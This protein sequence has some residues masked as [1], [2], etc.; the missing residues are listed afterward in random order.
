[1]GAMFAALDSI[2][3]ELGACAAHAAGSQKLQVYFH[4]RN[5]AAKLRLLTGTKGPL[6]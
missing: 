3:P 6:R 1:M 4:G 2:H 5:V